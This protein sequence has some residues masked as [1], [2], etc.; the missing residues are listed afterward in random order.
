MCWERHHLFKQPDVLQVLSPHHLLPCHRAD[1]LT[2]HCEQHWTSPWLTGLSQRQMPHWSLV[3]L[4]PL[5]QPEQE[6]SQTMPLAP[7]DNSKYVKMDFEGHRA[8]FPPYS[9][10]SAR[11]VSIMLLCKGHPHLKQVGLVQRVLHHLCLTEEPN[12]ITNCGSLIWYVAI[13]VNLLFLL[14]LSRVSEIQAHCTKAQKLQ[15]KVKQFSAV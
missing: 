9:E 5:P 10:F 4:L 8:L 14:T 6:G 2:T 1:P 13:S 12:S 15:A 3:L 11:L 7:Q